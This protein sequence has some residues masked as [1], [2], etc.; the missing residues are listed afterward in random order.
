MSEKK[1]RLIFDV[2]YQPQ[3]RTNVDTR[4]LM[5]D[6]LVAM[7]PIAIV[8]VYRY[9][10][11]V[12]VLMLT[13]MASATFFEWAYRRF[14]KK[15]ITIDDFSAAVSGLLLVMVLNYFVDHPIVRRTA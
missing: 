7:I 4:R 15:S 3:V 5:S 6:V 10:W 13:G 14:L 12:L 11:H 1:E 8:A 9:G 2:A